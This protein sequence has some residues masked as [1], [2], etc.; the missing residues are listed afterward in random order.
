[1][2]A[3]QPRELAQLHLCP[4]VL[5]PARDLLMAAGARL[6]RVPGL[7]AVSPALLALQVRGACAAT[8]AAGRHR[9]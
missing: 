5:R 2:R 6:A 9:R 1:M 7:E 3:T 8:G 4:A